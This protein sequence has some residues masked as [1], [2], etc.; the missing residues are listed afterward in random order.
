MQNIYTNALKQSEKLHAT[1][2]NG[3]LNVSGTV[4]AFEFNSYEGFYTVTAN[5]ETITRFNTRKLSQARQWLRE[6]LAN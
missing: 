5:S 2:K 3:T 1:A 6:Y 4:Y